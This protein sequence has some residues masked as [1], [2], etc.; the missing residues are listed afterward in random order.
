MSVIIGIENFWITTSFHFMNNNAPTILTEKL[1][2]FK[3]L[4]HMKHSQAKSTTAP[5]YILNIKHIHKKPFLVFPDSRKNYFIIIVLIE[6]F[7]LKNIALD[8]LSSYNTVNH[9]ILL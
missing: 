7:K 3:I 5:N 4:I 2:I 8:I 6:T 9:F 1:K